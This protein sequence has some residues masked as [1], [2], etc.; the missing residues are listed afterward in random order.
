MNIVGEN[1]P[2]QIID[3]INIRQKKKGALNRDPELL[4]WMNSNTGWVRI[5]SS[6]DIDESRYNFPNAPFQKDKPTGSTLA[7]QYI[8]SGGVSSGVNKGGLRYGIATDGSSL[9]DNAYG[10]GGL[11]FGIQPM[12]GITSF[13]IKTETRGSLKTA[14]I[15]IK[16]YNKTQFD[17]ISTLYLSLGYSILLEWGNTMYYDNKKTF[18]PDNSFSLANDF[19]SGKYKWDNILSSIVKNRLDSNGNYDAALGKVV[20]FSWTVD[21]DLSYNIILTVRTIGDVI[22]S[23]KVNTLS[24]NVKLTDTPSKSTSTSP[25]TEEAIVNFAKSSDVGAILYNI[26]TSLKKLNSNNIGESVLKDPTTKIVQAIK[27]VYKGDKPRE[28]YYI[29]LGYFLELLQEYIIFD[30]KNGNNKTKY[31][32]FDTDI[33]TNIISLCSRQLSADPSICLFKASYVNHTVQFIPDAEDF[34]LYDSDAKCF[35]GQL[36]NVYFN[37]NY[38]I[39]SLKLLV[40][41]NGNVMLIDFL[42][43]LSYGFCTATGNYNSIEPTVNEENNTIVFIDDV[44][45]PSILRNK[46]IKKANPLTSSTEAYFILYGFNQTNNGALAGIVRDINLTTTITPQLASMIT[47]G[48]QANGYITGQDSTALSTINRGLIDRVKQEIV[49]PITN[50]SPTASVKSLEE[51]YADTIKVFNK[52]LNTIG[53]VNGSNPG[54]DQNAINEFINT[55][56]YLIAY[57]QYT[58][59]RDAQLKNPSGSLSSPT[60]GFLPFGLTLTIDGISGMKVYQKFVIDS[61]FL[62][63]N[64]PESLEF[65]IKGV[66]H[67]IKNNQWITSIESFAIPKNPFG[68]QDT[69]IVSNGRVQG[70]APIT[71]GNNYPIANSKQYSN[72]KF[73]NIGQGNPSV[74]KVNPTVLSDVNK[75]AKNTGIIVSVTTAVS[76]HH[77]DPPSR[78]SS[79]DAIDIALV[80]GI[81]VNPN[82][83]NRTKIDTFVRALQSLGYTKNIESGTSKSVLTFGFP[84]HNNHIHVSSK[85]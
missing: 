76:E 1:F 75:A 33:E 55:N 48:A 56:R 10:L 38:I 29:R 13:S 70:A 4:T 11:E 68:T 15:G 81:Q 47:I 54:W 66:T 50:T 16:A 26:Q 83:P 52:F 25:T 41:T 30:V 31:I 39:S 28:E 17:I 2:Q 71:R 9:N 20:N 19:L 64:Y 57:E 14:T 60:I 7:K 22:E 8:L 53:S 37:I 3:Q 72:I 84:N 40:D 34:K 49:D 62:P 44:P 46:I 74:D 82:A 61:N 63:S 12:P 69:P 6:V 58:Q 73:Q 80:D 65:I 32:T 51:Q 18:H 21:K 36:M 45:L 77:N 42:K 79:G 78:H 59:T 23:L 67:E 43:K 35:Y 27:Q 5:V 24:G 85:V